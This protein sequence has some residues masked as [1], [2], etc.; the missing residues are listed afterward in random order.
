[1]SS[2]FLPADFENLPGHSI[3][4]V[5]G[6]QRL[7][8]ELIELR[9]L[10][11]HAYAEQP[12]AVTLLDTASRQELPQ[13]IYRYEHPTRGAIDLFTVPLGPSDQGMRYEIVFN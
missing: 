5:H 3:T 4:L 2:R 10:Q 6:E 12:F 13:S 1:M 9:R 8:L 7:T 11:P